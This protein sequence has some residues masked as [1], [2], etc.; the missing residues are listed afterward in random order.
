[1]LTELQKR[2]AQAIVNIFET[3]EPRGDYGRVTFLKGDSGHLTYGR[4]QTTLASGNLYL[5]LKA[6][7]DDEDA[8]YAAPLRHYLSRL[9]QRETSLDYNMTLH[10]ILQK[11]GD[12]PVMQE[13]QDQFFD[14]AYWEPS[15]KSAREINIETALGIAVIYDSRIHGSW[16]LMR[17]RTLEQYGDAGDIGEETWIKQYIHTRRGWLATHRIPILHKTVYRM[18]AFFSLIQQDNWDLSFPFYVRGTRIDEGAIEPPLPRASAQNDTIRLL[19]LKNPYLRGDDVKDVQEALIR[20]GYDLTAD[21][22][23]GRYTEKALKEFQDDRQLRVDGIVG[24]VVLAFL[25][26]L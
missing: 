21:G 18:D 26:I 12:D 25:G 11:A 7:C 1:M 14:R 22:I 10:T 5:L 23:F 9:L 17:D 16:K 15:L 24:P 4:S 8:Q 20:H 2:A 3:G 6:Y 19:Y 13:V